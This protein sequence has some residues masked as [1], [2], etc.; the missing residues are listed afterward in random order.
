MTVTNKEKLIIT[1]SIK[2]N[3]PISKVWDALINPEITKKYM[4]G[5]E[6]ISDFKTGSRI[7]WQATVDGKEMVFV[8]GKVVEFAP[9]QRFAY[10]TFDPNSDLEDIPENHVTA[11]CI[12]EEHEGITTLTV[13]HGD[14]ATAGDGQ[15]RYDETLQSGGWDSVLLQIKEL[16][17]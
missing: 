6:V 3:A 14:F 10:T 12:L 17:E 1:G 2:I 7:D 4:F 5:C 11:T 8:T 15:K 16:V 13:T 9:M